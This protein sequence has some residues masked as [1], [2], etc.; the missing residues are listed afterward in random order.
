MFLVWHCDI[1]LESIAL[2][3]LSKVKPE[4]LRFWEKVHTVYCTRG[5]LGCQLNEL[6]LFRYFRPLNDASHIAGAGHLTLLANNKLVR[7]M[8]ALFA[9]VLSPTKK[10]WQEGLSVNAGVDSAKIF[11]GLQVLGK[12]SFGGAKGD[13]WA[14]GCIMGAFLLRRCSEKNWAYCMWSPFP[15]ATLAK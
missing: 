13:M 3:S 5:T 11:C 6:F 4:F 8:L 1:W 7:F 15:S 10:A 12:E 2:S 9:S 14:L